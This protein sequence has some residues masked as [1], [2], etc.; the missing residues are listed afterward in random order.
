MEPEISIPQEKLQHQ[1]AFSLLP[2]PLHINSFH[3]NKG[4]NHYA[5]QIHYLGKVMFILCSTTNS[6]I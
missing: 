1:T 6:Y 4:I 3:I 2:V 5:I